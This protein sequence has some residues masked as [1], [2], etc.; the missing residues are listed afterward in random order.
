MT[1][2][3]RIKNVTKEWDGQPVFEHIDLEVN[4]GDRIALFGRNGCGKTTLLRVLMGEEEPDEGRIEA[5]LP[6]DRWGWMRQSREQD[7][8]TAGTVL[9]AVQEESHELYTLKRQLNHL[10]QQMQNMNAA[11]EE[12]QELEQYGEWLE[13]YEALGGYAWESEVEKVLS[14]MGIPEQLWTSP[15]RELSGGQQTKVRLAAL[16]V[17]RPELLIL[18][19]PTNHLDGDSLEWLE[20]QLSAYEGTILFVSHDREFIDR[21]ATAIA[22]LSPSGL[23][24]Y[25]G[26]YSAY[27]VQKEREWTEQ[28]AQYR[29]QELARKALE[30]TIRNYQQWFHAAHQAAADVEVGITQSFYKAK[31]NKNISRYHAKEKELE[32]LEQNRV[33]KPKEDPKLRLHLEAHSLRAR[34]LVRMEQVNFAYAADQSPIICGVNLNV[35]RGDVIAVRGANGSGKS[36]LLKLITGRL[37]PTGG[38]VRLHPQLKIG[39]FS[40]L[41]ED[42][43]LYLTLLDSLLLLPSMTQTEARTILGCFLFTREDV[44]RTIGDLSMG[45]KCRAAFIHLYFGGSNLLVL[46][47]PTNY[48]D[49]DTRQVMEDVLQSYDGAVVLVSHDRMLVRRT[50]NRLLD[51]SAGGD[52]SL[53]EGSVEELEALEPTRSRALARRED[54]DE[55]MRLEWR[56]NELLSQMEFTELPDAAVNVDNGVNH[57]LLEEIR[58]IQAKLVRLRTD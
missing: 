22:E 30:E 49:I 45:E 3:L 51:L 19:E 58:V 23:T 9:E 7:G 13:R 52:W 10:L 54:D 35:G 40:Q 27:R 4:K 11:D 26:N 16:M 33:E 6:R 47:E 48:L 15:C 29:K 20:Q 37:E 53:F 39:Y 41:L 28:E 36:T 14:R 2:I 1:A 25:K 38:G 32:R 55:A 43:P 5:V 8:Q 31:A 24:K 56:L 12:A 50:A 44:Y 21:V 17:R 18:D 42:L 57:A 46:D 34:Y